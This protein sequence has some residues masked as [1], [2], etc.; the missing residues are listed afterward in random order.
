MYNNPLF[1]LIHCLIFSQTCLSHHKL[2]EI[3]SLHQNAHDDVLSQVALI[4]ADAE[5]E[6]KHEATSLKT[7]RV[8]GEEARKA[9]I[10]LIEVIFGHL[11]NGMLHLLTNEEGRHQVCM[12]ILAATALVFAMS[13]SKEL[14]SVIFNSVIRFFSMPRLVREWG[15]VSSRN[16]LRKAQISDIILPKDDKNRIVELCRTINKGRSRK[17]PLRN[18]L[19]H[20]KTGTGKSMIARAI[21]ESALD[22]PFAIMSG[23]DIAPLDHLGPSELRNVLSWANRQRKGGIIIMDEAESALGKRMRRQ[24]TSKVD[25]SD[26][27]SLAPAR[28]ALNV[29]LSMTGESGGNIM[30]ILTTSNPSALD[31]A[32]LDRCDEMIICKEP[33]T[34]ERFGILGKELNKR[35]NTERNTSQENDSIF[36]KFFLRKIKYLKLDT[37]FSVESALKHL[38]KDDMTLDFSGRELSKIIRAVETAVYSSE[39][40]ILT[41]EIWNAVVHDLCMSIKSK[42]KLRKS[43]L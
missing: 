6:R 35:F 36:S 42:K 28:D 8:L 26:G 4:H 11:V 27:Q 41:M 20:G 32:V 40:N 18:V 2:S 24:K 17:A 12:A 14:I 9:L 25:S 39:N 3:K 19:I 22:V 10:Q 30:I 38:S 37:S 13:I 34:R 29:F 7:I 21:A 1:V 31:E 15:C 33:G 16:Q 5:E 43:K 23:A